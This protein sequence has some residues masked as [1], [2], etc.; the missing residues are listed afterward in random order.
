MF[1]SKTRIANKLISKV[2]GTR[3]VAKKNDS[4]SAFSVSVTRTAG[5]C[6]NFIF[7]AKAMKIM[8]SEK[9]QNDQIQKEIIN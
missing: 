3:Y 1:I 4:R 5:N 7:C 6:G 8:R 9:C 2:K